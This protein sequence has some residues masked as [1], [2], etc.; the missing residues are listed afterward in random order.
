MLASVVLSLAVAA[1][2]KI[3]LSD[4]VRAGGTQLEPGKYFLSI[5]GTTAVLKDKG[6]KT[7]A[8]AKVEE[9]AEKAKFTSYGL[10]PDRQRLVTVTVR[11]SRA[12]VVFE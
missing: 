1:E 3:S 8:N 7:V 4:K 12:R 6:G 9:M 2:F 11:G 5:D 10:S